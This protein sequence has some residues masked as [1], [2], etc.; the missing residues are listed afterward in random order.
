MS[1]ETIVYQAN[2]LITGRRDFSLIETRLFYIGLRDIVPKLTSK[3]TPWGN[4]EDNDFP[5]TVIPAKELVTMFGNDKYYNT[6]QGI[7]ENMA[8]KTVKIKRVGKKGFSV[9][10]VFA[11][12]TYTVDEG[13]KLEFNSKM[14]PWLLDLADKPFTKL[15][16]EQ[17]WA[18]RSSYAVRLLELLLQYQNTKTHERTLTI[19]EIRQSLGVPDEAYRDRMNN[20][21]RYIIENTIKDINEKTAY[22]V[23]YESVKEGRKIVAFKFKLHLPAD[24]KREKRKKQ[25]ADIGRLTDEA[26]NASKKK[27]ADIQPTGDY[28]EPVIIDK[29]TG[30]IVSQ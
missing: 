15:P 19:D 1:K 9:Y 25:I 7:C 10:P 29:K 26:L 21:K 20:F 17:I 2:P 22:K 8:E 12:L 18:L 14:K 23:E 28:S 16:F 27:S 13:L 30:K 5:V 24:I 3:G 4:R 11:E 6:L